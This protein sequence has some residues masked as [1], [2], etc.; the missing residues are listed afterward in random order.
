MSSR[1][2]P[3]ASSS[4]VGSGRR[5]RADGRMGLVLRVLLL[6]LVADVA[7]CAA[8]TSATTVESRTVAAG[9][10]RS[11]HVTL[12]MQP[13]NLQVRG[14][15]GQL[16]DA[17]FTYQPPAWKP[18]ICYQVRSGHGELAVRQPHLK[19]VTSGHNTWDVKLSDRIPVDLAVTSGPGNA[20]LGI[21][22]LTLN[23]L[24]LVAGPGNVSVDAGSPFLRTLTVSTGPGNLSVDL[25]APWTHSVTANIN[26]QIGNTTLR[27]PAAVGVRVAVQGE[28]VVVA[29]DF[30]EQ[31]GAYV[32]SQFGRSK[33]TVRVSLSAGIGNVVLATET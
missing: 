9:P 27:L 12:A 11:V 3:S 15:A 29:P 4:P 17:R 32:N 10:A 30:T 6:V 19:H 16:L 13:G 25:A 28:A 22:T 21:R 23:T 31:E 2:G 14:G 1:L 24:T 33:V 18:T 5:A 8:G 7:G 20:T 26:A